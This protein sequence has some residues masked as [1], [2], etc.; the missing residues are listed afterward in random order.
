[1]DGDRGQFDMTA[2]C[3]RLTNGANAVSQLHAETANATWQGITDHDILGIT[4]G[5]HGPSWVGAPIAD[6]LARYLD[7]DLDDLDAATA[8]GPLLGAHGAR[9]GA[10]PVGG[11]P[12]PEARARAL[13]PAAGCAAS[14]PATARRRRVLAELETRARPGRPDHRVRPAVRDLQARRPAVHATST[15]SSRMLWDAD[16]PIQ[17]V[18]AGKAHPADRPGQRVIQEIFQ[19]SRSPQLRGRVFILEDYD[20][21][22]GRFLVQGVDVWL[23]NPRR[24]LEASG[25]SGMKAAQN[26]VPNISVLDGWWDEGY[27]ERQRL[28]H[29]RP[30]DQPRRGRAGLGRRPGPLPDPRGGDHPALL[31]AR[32][33]RRPAALARRSCA[34]RWRPRSGGSRRPGCSTSTPSGSTCRPPASPSAEAGAAR[35]SSPRPADRRPWP[36]G[37]RSPSPSTTTSRSATSAGC[38]PRS[39]SRP[40]CRCSRPSSA[41]PASALSLHYTGPLLEWLRGRAPGVHRPAARRSSPASQ[42]EIL[43]GGFYEPVLASLP[44]R[45]RIGQLRRMGD[46]LEALFGRRPRGAWLAERVWE[47]DLPTSL[48]AGGYGWT[49]LDDAH[50][51]AAA[52]PEEDLWGPYTTE[53][54]GQLLRVF[55]TEQGLRYRIPFRD[56]EDVIDYLRDHATE[57]GERVGMMGDDGEKFGAWPTTWEHCWGDGRWVER[58]FEALEAN[59]DWL[60]TVT[61]SA[62]LAE[63]RPIGRVYVPTGSYAEMGEWALPADESL[64]LRRRRCI[65]RRPSG[66][67]EARW[68]R[69]AFWRNFQ[70]KYREINDLHKQMLRTSDEGRRDAGGPDRD[71]R[72]RPPLPGP[73]QRLLLARPVRRHLHQPHAPRDVRAPHRR[74]GPRRRRRRARSMRPSAATSTWTASTRSGSPTAGPGR[75]GRPRRGRRHRRLGH[76]RRRGTR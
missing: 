42:V 68:L 73:V 54:Q 37:S 22:V 23:N 45:D 21:R 76:P 13:R 64:R 41:T 9:P 24:P 47:P 3:L 6:L 52:I 17:I 31:R 63:H 74:R 19:R 12:A 51:R 66:R 48:V 18:F 4:N 43:G 2:F 50:F 28:G 29:R 49:I 33:D 39:T 32:R 69:G 44:E 70:V 35:R 5:V 11:A 60:S 56:V 1:M 14:S 71:A 16:R 67:P 8:A 59:A 27:A 10:R 34:G 30:R 65:A 53:D 61:P 58:F 36:R 62:W 20:M 26:G 38:S 57:D 40:T 25:T 46:E 55:G 7:A 75:D 72:P 15:G